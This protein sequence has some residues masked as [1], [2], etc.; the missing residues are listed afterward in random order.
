M[1][2]FSILKERLGELFRR[3]SGKGKLSE[4]DLRSFLRDLRRTLLEADVSHRVAK[5]FVERVSQRASGAKLVS[6]ISP[7]QQLLTLVYEEMV[8]LL[9][10]A[11]GS[12]IRWAALPPT[13]VLMVGLQGSGKTTTCAKLARRFKKG[14][15]V[16]LVAADLKRPAAVRQLEILASQVGVDFMGPEGGEED[17]ISLCRRV[18][19]RA[20]DRLNDLVIVDT[21]GRLHVDEELMEELKGICEVLSPHERILVIDAMVG[22]EALKVA[23]AFH[24]ALGLTGVILSKA[25]GD[26]RGGV[27]LSV[28]AATGVPIKFVGVGEK[29]EDLEGFSA[30][31]MAG[32]I[33]GMGDL[34]GLLEKVKEAS[35]EESLRASAERLKRAEF[36]MEDMLEQIRQIRRMGGSSLLQMLPGGLGASLGELELDERRLKHLEAVILS[37]TPEERRRPEIVKASRKRR[38]AAGSGTSVQLVNQVLKQYFAMR[39][40][41]K[42][43]SSHKRKGGLF[44]LSKKILGF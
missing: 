17:P 39:E 21:A 3:V 31:G 33:L 5:E 15:S 41:V 1:R 34:Q 18:I 32:R 14:H 24:S 20:R 44:G 12:G 8:S 7:A 22:Q 36:T 6:S 9:G 30:Q 43:V 23:E 19:P 13:V 16:L 38:I 42:S 27:A 35:D 29:V 11:E 25:D 28:R 2:M 40:L 37:M 4:E 26:A 10:G